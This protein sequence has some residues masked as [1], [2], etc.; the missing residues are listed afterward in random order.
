MNLFFY[1]F[2]GDKEMTEDDLKNVEILYKNE[3]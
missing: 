2:V 3:D 1:F